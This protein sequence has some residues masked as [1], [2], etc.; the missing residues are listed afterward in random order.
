LQA[1]LL[2]PLRS[3][4]IAFYIM[5]SSF[6]LF[7]LGAS[8]AQS[9]HWL[10]EFGLYFRL[11]LEI[12]PSSHV[13]NSPWWSL[14]RPD[15]SLSWFLNLGAKKPERETTTCF[16]SCCWLINTWIYTSTHACVFILGA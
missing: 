9:A 8:T 1:F 4:G 11:K 12:F 14:Q 7:P 5:Y 10:Q 2:L 15:R 13:S 3:N 6:I 16:C